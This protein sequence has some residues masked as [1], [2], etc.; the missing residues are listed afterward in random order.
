MN[1]QLYLASNSERIK[2]NRL[3]GRIWMVILFLSLAYL[4]GGGLSEDGSVI[5]SVDANFN[6]GCVH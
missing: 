2:K 4:F 5:M 1:H 6:S 3:K